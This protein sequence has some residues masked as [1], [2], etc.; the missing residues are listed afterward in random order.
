MNLDDFLDN[1]DDWIGHDADNKHQVF[2]AL[3]KQWRVAN[4]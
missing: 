2:R 3:N 4:D 1:E